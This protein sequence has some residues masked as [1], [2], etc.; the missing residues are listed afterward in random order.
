MRKITYI[1]K[2]M[3]YCIFNDIFAICACNKNNLH[4]Q[5]FAQSNNLN[6]DF[7]IPNI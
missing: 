1:L 7:T 5:F 2:S 6:K 3:I 4:E